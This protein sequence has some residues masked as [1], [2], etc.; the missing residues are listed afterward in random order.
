V[1]RL[2]LFGRQGAGKGT[3]ATALAAHYGAPHI[4]TGDMLREAVASGTEFGLKAKVYMDEGQLLP[5]DVMLG[6]IS[7]RLARSDVEQNGF[8]LDGYPRTVGQAEAL[9]GL[10]DVD[11]AANLEVPEQIVLDRISSRRVCENCGRIYSISVRPGHDW[12]C[13]NC[14]GRVVQRD[15][16]KPAAIA[17]RLDAYREQTVPAIEWFDSKGLLVCV[18]GLGTP[19]EVT[20][21]LIA[22]IDERVSG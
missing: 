22:A 12:E 16:D 4:S 8:L 19:E 2:V 10:S 6:V 21:R 11:V 7:E 14:G 13:D 9:V 3:Q 20:D 18:D 17:Q 5:D 1:L 15:D